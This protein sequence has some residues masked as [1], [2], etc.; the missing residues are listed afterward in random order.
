MNLIEKN[1]KRNIKRCSNNVWKAEIECME[2][3]ESIKTHHKL[4]KCLTEDKEQ[5]G[6]RISLLEEHSKEVLMRM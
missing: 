4:L 3:I 1:Y 2:R 5:M 6:V